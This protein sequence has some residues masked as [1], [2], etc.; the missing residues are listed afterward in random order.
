MTWPVVARVHT[1]LNLPW[2]RT[3]FL[4]LCSLLLHPSPFPPPAPEP[5][6]SNGHSAGQFEV[7]K[8]VHWIVERD[9]PGRPAKKRTN[10]SDDEDAQ[11]PP[12][13][14]IY[15]QRQQKRVK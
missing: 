10:D 2:V 5:G 12:A 14:D 8:S 15:R 6:A 9:A 11:A 4:L 13:N 7:A 3:L 1:S